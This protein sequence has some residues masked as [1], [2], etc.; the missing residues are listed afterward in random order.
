MSQGE[1]VLTANTLTYNERTKTVSASGNAALMD[2]SGNVVFADYME[3]TDDLKDGV[4]KNIKVLL[5][6]KSRIAAVHADRKGPTDEFNKG[7][8]SPCRPCVDKPDSM[9]PPIWQLAAR[10]IVHDNDEHEIVYH[11]AWMEIFGVPVIFTPYF[12]M[13]D[14]SVKRK[15]GFLIPVI[16][17]SSN[18]GF[19]YRQP[20]FWAIAPDKDLTITPLINSKA[21]PVLVGEYRQRLVDGKITVDFAGTDINLSNYQNSNGATIP[22]NGTQPE[23]YV[24]AVG[25]FDLSDN[26]RAGFD[27]NRVTNPA[28]LQLFGLPGQYNSSLN[29]EIYGEG[30]QSR[31][32]ASIQAW[33][34]QNM[35]QNGTPNS[36]L[37]IITPIVNYDLVGEPNQFGA[38]WSANLNSMIL[39][40]ISGTDSRRLVGQVAWTLPYIAPAGDIYKLTLS[41]R[42]DGYWVNDV[43][44]ASNTDPTPDPSVATFNGF[45]GRIFPQ[46]AFD[47]RYPFQR[48]TGHTT[49]VFEPIFSAIIAPNDG[50]PTTIPN[51]DSQD[52]QLDETNL[53]DARR[54]TGYDIAD[55]GQRFNYGAR[56]SIIGDDGGSTSFFL[57]QSY[58]VGGATAYDQGVDIGGNFSDVVGS[59]D[60]RAGPGL[61]RDLPLPGRRLDRRVPAPGGHGPARD[62]PVQRQYQLYL[63]QWGQPRDLPQRHGAGDLWYALL[64]DRRQLV[65]LLLGTARS[66]DQS[67]PRI[68]RGRELQERLHLGEPRRLG[69]QLYAEQRRSPAPASCSPSGSRTWGPMASPS[70]LLRLADLLRLARFCLY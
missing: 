54:V 58:Q 37:P 52:F 45:T 65:R 56:Y 62:P 20:Y 53:F 4:I 41:L 31:S 68:W 6:D 22:D 63:P 16:G 14:P 61:R 66:G 38:Y 43:D 3:V 5:N 30:F 12:S 36:E 26:W 70:N 18:F 67:E 40:R 9:S 13:P 39:S 21:P 10:R 64:P 35:L 59:G 17:Q 48:R 2:Q 57:G 24:D 50:N 15:S 69:Q 11:D 46:L 34:F 44:T 1:R 42:A 51:E 19:Q 33:S 23:G 7:V 32:Y 49:Q 29:S 28:F 25:Q 8:Y 27:I 60:G 55:S 47:W